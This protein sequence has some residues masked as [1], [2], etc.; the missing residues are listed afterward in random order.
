[1]G[2]FAILNDFNGLGKCV[3]DLFSKISAL[4]SFFGLMGW[5]LPPSRKGAPRFSSKRIC[6]VGAVTRTG[7]KGE[8]A[9]RIA[10]EGFV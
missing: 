8:D 2:H 7:R 3:R 1:M 5:C 6:A 4:L 10:G 9:L